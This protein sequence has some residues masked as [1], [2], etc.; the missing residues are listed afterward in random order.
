MRKEEI[1]HQRKCNQ[2]INERF[3]RAFLLKAFHLKLKDIPRDPL[4]YREFRERK[5]NINWTTLEPSRS[6]KKVLMKFYV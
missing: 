5:N 6:Q 4:D 3:A 1:P 2:C